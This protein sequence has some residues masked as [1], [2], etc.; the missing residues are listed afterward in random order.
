MIRIAILDDHELIRHS[1]QSLIRA[2]K[3][4]EVSLVAACAAELMPQLKQHPVH[5]L[6]LDLNLPDAEGLD[7]IQKIRHR[8]SQIRILVLSM[9][10]EED[11]ALRVI[12]AG[13]QGYISKSSSGSEIIHAIRSVYGTG[14]YISGVTVEQLANNLFSGLPN[15]HEQ[16]SQREFQ[17]L[18]AIG[19]GKTT[20]QVADT[21]HL[22]LNTIHTYRRRLMGKMAFNSNNEIVRYC[23][24][25]KL[26]V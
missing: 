25:H 4:M 7:L 12:R 17:V 1:L 18:L 13:A 11:Y 24:E 10:T 26:I 3:G 22:S 14:R 21:L 20:A 15:N 8:Y 23:I 6:L 19:Q 9:H 2:E 5:I 16:L